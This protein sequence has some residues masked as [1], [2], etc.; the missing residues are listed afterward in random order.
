MTAFIVW[1]NPMAGKMKKILCSDWV[2]EHILPARDFPRRF[3]REKLF[4]D[5][6]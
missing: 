2:P 5:I 6:Q 3:H 4:L 1:Q